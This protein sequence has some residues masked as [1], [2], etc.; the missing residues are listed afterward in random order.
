LR[1]PLLSEYDPLIEGEG[2]IDPLG[3]QP[4]YERLAD[5]LL[6]AV[7]VRMGRPRFVTAIAVG[8]W[9]CQEW[10]SDTVA[11]DKVTPPWLVYEWFV[12]EAFVRSEKVLGEGRRIP[13]VLKAQRAWRD[14]RP[15]SA[16][17]YLKTPTVFGFTGIFRR[18]ARHLRVITEEGRLDDAGYE[19]LAA[20]SAEQGLAGFVDG[21]DSAGA[22]FRKSLGRAVAQGLELGHTRRQSQDFC[23]LIARSLDPAK[24][25]RRERKVLLRLLED[26]AGPPEMPETMPHLIGALRKRGSTLEFSQEAAFLT[27][28]E[29]IAS[30]TLRELLSAISAYE[31]FGRV[32]TDAFKA[33]RHAA[34]QAGGAC[35]GRE[36]FARLVSTDCATR[37]ATAIARIRRHD[38]LVQ[39]EPSLEATL[40]RFDHAKTRDQLY[41][42]LLDHHRCVQDDKGKRTWFQPGR[43]DRIFVRPD[44]VLTD[45]PPKGIAHVHEYRMP[46]FSRFLD[47]LG[48][49]S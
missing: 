41:D 22:Q 25:G 4:I 8:A 10:H 18:L 32:I 45:P 28:V 1:A 13:G 9:V 11:A 7:T 48:A 29:K 43:G 24:V 38:R 30:A 34:A 23:D 40:T 33:L 14:G 16:S 31:V 49:L 44:Y 2:S 26:R 46:T 3:L 47:D 20:W 36:D 19:L 21:A 27:S 39:W 37:L 42:V 12:V 6:P 17:S 15:I 5:R 35:I